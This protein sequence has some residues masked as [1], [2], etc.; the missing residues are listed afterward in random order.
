MRPSG[1]LPQK[2]ILASM[3]SLFLVRGSHA[4]LMN[5]M[6]GT[7]TEKPAILSAK[8]E[9]PFK[10]EPIDPDF[11]TRI[12][13]AEA[14]GNF[15]KIVVLAG[16]LLNE[17][18]NGSTDEADEARLALGIGLSR[19]KLSYGATVILKGLAK[20]RNGSKIGEAALIELSRLAQE[21]FYDQEEIAEDLLVSN[22]FAP[23]HSE[24]ESFI[25]Y[26]AG[27]YNLAR[28]FKTWSDKEFGK[29]KPGTYWDY[30]LRYLKALGEIARD[31]VENGRQRLEEL[32][33]DEQVPKIIR[34]KARL[35][36]A[37]LA[38]E[39]GD[40]RNSYQLYA[41][42]D[43]PIRTKGRLFVERAWAQFYLKN[44]SKAL[45]LLE[46]A[47]TPVFSVSDHP[48]RYVLGMLIYR[49]LCHYEAVIETAE[50]FR[51]R[52]GDAL[53][54][55][56]ARGDLQKVPIIANMAMAHEK[57]QDEV[58]YLN[59][60][61]DEFRELQDYDWDE[62]DFYD[63]LLKAYEFKNTNQIGRIDHMIMEKSRQIALQIV[64]T[65]EQIVF[66]DYTA[67]LDQL[68]IVRRGE[69]RD[70]KSEQ[71][72]F[73]RF[74]KLFWPVTSEHWVDELEDYTMLIRSRCGESQLSSPTQGD[75]EDFE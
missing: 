38:F 65:E 62:Y 26:H 14:E 52:F 67:K 8:E 50:Q 29:I 34:E 1:N 33:I 12:T 19:M 24:V 55:I 30:K 10:Y 53:E 58:N 47:K 3:M 63:Q 46:V 73:L 7:T 22:E 2:L 13:E 20:S 25:G 27:L 59:Q 70:Y 18:D 9:G 49:E 21:R 5:P 15:P 45:G 41:D 23:Y 71:I 56:R 64:E 74:D 69:N 48:E 43:L 61:R 37:R 66:L 54:A 4:Q 17:E 39:Q 44:Y 57:I 28:G 31:R 51:D 35:Q 40:F 6:Q 36:V 11:W 32:R 42:L 16:D 68:R 75:A 60:T 72:N